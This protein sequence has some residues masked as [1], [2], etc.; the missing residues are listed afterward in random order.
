M[1]V[2]G[3]WP[4]FGGGRYSEVA[5]IRRWPLFGGGRYS[6]VAAIRRWP[7]FGGGRYS[8][9]AAIRRWP[10]LD[11]RLY[12]GNNK[13][14]CNKNLTEFKLTF[15]KSRFISCLFSISCNISI[16]F[17]ILSTFVDTSSLK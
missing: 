11:V 1:A 5:A 14:N 12:Y 16:L 10:H 3:R 4:L 7:L 15:F 6:E 17:D 2:I 13:N 8:E 9:V